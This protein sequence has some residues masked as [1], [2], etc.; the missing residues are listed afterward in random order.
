MRQLSGQPGWAKGIRMSVEI[1]KESRLTDR[2]IAD[3]MNLYDACNQYDNTQYVFDEEDDFKQENDINTFLLYENMKL[4]S[5]LNI[6]APTKAEAEITAL[7]M[8]DSR[9]MG[10]FK[11]LLQCAAG[12]I[13]RRDI[14][15]ILFVCD[16]KSRNAVD[17]MA[18][19]NATYEYSEFLM[20]YRREENKYSGGKKDV[21]ISVARPADKERLVEI[22]HLA[23]NNGMN[24]SREI[25]EEFYNSE[26]RV[27]YSIIMKNEVIGMIGI[28]N[29]S[30]R[31]YIYGFCIDSK[32]QKQGIGKYVLNE[33]V[34]RQGKDKKIV[35]EVQVENR[36]ALKVYE[37]V[38][39]TI[40]AEYRY[41]REA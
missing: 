25:M 14:K 29:E 41:Y 28:Y 35:L 33:L 3:I 38:G 1:I 7:T 23:F 30:A 15:S 12:E 37:D 36:N 26:R 9:N 2:S 34:S 8:P 16:S 24:E 39:F 40:E 32:Y 6:F 21:S 27:L 22:N 10:Y 20:E 11:L 31:K 13:S 18:H 4:V 5:S 19:I 17:V